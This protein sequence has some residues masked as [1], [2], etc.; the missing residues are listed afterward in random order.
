VRQAVTRN[1]DK[2]NAGRKAGAKRYLR[3]KEKHIEMLSGTRR[4]TV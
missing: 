2:R 3:P 1:Q 4:R